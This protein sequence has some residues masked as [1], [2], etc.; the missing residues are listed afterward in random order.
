M[1]S[2]LSNNASKSPRIHGESTLKS[3]TSK[4]TKNW[5]G[6]SFILVWLL[7]WT[8]IVGCVDCFVSYDFY[9]QLVA[10]SYEQVSGEVT[11]SEV[12]TDHD[13]DGTTYRAIVHYQYSV[14]GKGYSNDVIR[15]GEVAS[16]DSYAHEF[17]AAHP[18][19]TKVAVYYDSDDPSQAV[20]LPGISGGQL[21]LLMFLTPF[22]VVMFGGWFLVI[23]DRYPSDDWLAR[24]VIDDGYEIRIVVNRISPFAVFAGS[25]LG[26]CFFSI[27]IVAFTFGP[28]A[29]LQVMLVVWAIILVLCCLPTVWIAARCWSGYYDIVCERFNQTV[30]L[31]AQKKRSQPLRVGYRE[32]ETVQ[33][34]TESRRDSD[35][36]EHHKYEVWLTLGDKRPAIASAR[37]FLTYFYEAEKAHHFA[38]WFEYKVLKSAGPEKS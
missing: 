32:V 7:F 22:N 10:T 35:G 38:N 9:R 34:V 2:P 4:P 17:V 15:F 21:F 19:G 18:V 6:S 23:L 30:T 1:P 20:L 11:H 16:G 12:E 8:L 5:A 31:P 27:F 26:F 14:A 37:E 13:S 33:V 25:L 3:E 29:S 36:D 24:K 28:H